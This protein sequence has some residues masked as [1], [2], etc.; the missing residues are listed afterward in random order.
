[1]RILPYRTNDNVIEGLVLTFVNVTMMKTIQEEHARLLQSLDGSQVNV[2]GQDPSLLI[3]W[4]SGSPFGKPPADLIGK[5]DKE[6]FVPEDT[7]KLAA[8]KNAV[9]ATGIARRERAQ[10]AGEQQ[11][12]DLYMKPMRDAAG[13]ISGIACVAV[14]IPHA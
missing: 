5:S 8:V 4:V 11:L 13:R 12:Y 1:M 10:I 9:L 14:Q 2:Y 3:T 7:A 6:L